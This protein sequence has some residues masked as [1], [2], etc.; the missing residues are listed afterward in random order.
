MNMLGT[1]ITY[2]MYRFIISRIYQLSACVL[3]MLVVL[4][5]LIGAEDYADRKRDYL[6]AVRDMGWNAEAKE[7][8]VFREPQALSILAAGKDRVF[9][10][11]KPVSENIV[12]VGDGAT[13]YLDKNF[14]SVQKIIDKA[15]M[16]DP[17]FV[18]RVC[19]SLLV[20]FIGFNVITGEKESGTLRQVM[21]SG[22]P[23]SV[24]ILGKFTAGVLLIACTVLCA[25]A[26]AFLVIGLHP[27]VSFS[28]EEIA[29]GI[30][31]FGASF[32]Y[33]LVFFVISMSVSCMVHRSSAAL[34]ILFQIW[35]ALVVIV[36][37]AG[38]LITEHFRPLKT[39]TFAES[40][41]AIQ[42]RQ[43]TRIRDFGGRTGETALQRD[44]IRF[45]SDAEIYRQ[46]IIPYQ[47]AKR[48]QAAFARRITM[49]SPS[50][51]F[52]RII[53]RLART[54]DIEFARFTDQFFA[55]WQE[56]K[57]PEY[58]W[59]IPDDPPRFSYIPSTLG[60]ALVKRAGDTLAFIIFI[61]AGFSLSYVTF[62]RLD[63]R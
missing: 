1:V 42:E 22:I 56:I 23:R 7:M 39:E 12:L 38:V 13:S 18:M 27:D 32:G 17:A 11:K 4:T 8:N 33:G 28:N 10:V 41:A 63:V 5:T 40:M 57:I 55:Y 51:L 52:D 29:R 31:F 53:L 24:Y 50:V 61:L 44:K 36:P 58:W 49:F 3:I 9:G 46:A 19:F 48:E 35:I 62:L 47:L 45:E 60:N 37:N 30:L 15:G 20:M 6:D 14:G 16:V 25:G 59:H 26:G 34:L 21:A 54:D 43:Q 2:E